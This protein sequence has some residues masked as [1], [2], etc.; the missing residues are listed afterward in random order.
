MQ[1]ALILGSRLYFLPL[2]VFKQKSQS[3]PIFIRGLKLQVLILASLWSQLMF[4]S[5][6]KVIHSTINQ[7]WK[8]SRTDNLH[9]NVLGD[10]LHFNVFI[11]THW[12]CMYEGDGQSASTCGLLFV[13][14][15]LKVSSGFPVADVSQGEI[16][17]TKS[18]LVG[19][20]FNWGGADSLAPWEGSFCIS[21]HP[22]ELVDNAH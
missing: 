12:K 20:Y 6:A 19:A 15:E 10:L 13:Q 9:G 21:L 1:G 7:R 16:T 8:R 18:G 11:K 5:E 17:E 4:S 22:Q 14:V 3:W 2:K